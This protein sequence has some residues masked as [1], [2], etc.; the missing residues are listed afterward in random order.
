MQLT[1]LNSNLRNVHNDF[2]TFDLLDK[3]FYP[4]SSKDTFYPPYNT[5]N[6]GESTFI[7]LA[8]TG[9]KKKELKAYFN[10]EGLFVVEGSKTKVED[11]P[12]KEYFERNLSTKNFTRK[13][14]TPK[15]TELKEVKVENGL[16][17]IE[18]ERVK[19]DIKYIDI[20]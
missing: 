16:M 20:K 12:K 9:F 10:D 13:F 11:A 5:Y 17:T 2:D 6:V 19:P 7:E 14:R 4:Q 18:F 15:N 8:V 3:F 1:T